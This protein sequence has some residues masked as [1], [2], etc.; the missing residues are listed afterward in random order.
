MIGVHNRH[1]G[2][3]ISGHDRIQSMSYVPKGMDTVAIRSLPQAFAAGSGSTGLRS[4]S[5][6]GFGHKHF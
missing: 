4:G 6:S 5:S 3:K 1:R 2:A